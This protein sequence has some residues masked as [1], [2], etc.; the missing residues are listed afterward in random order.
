MTV[1]QQRR[2]RPRVPDWLKAP[3]MESPDGSMALVDH[4]RELRYRVIMSFIAFA[5]ITI[6]AIILEA[7]SYTHLTL[8]TTPYV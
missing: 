2:L 5:V 6:G 8:P 7:V 4:L 1:T 3:Q